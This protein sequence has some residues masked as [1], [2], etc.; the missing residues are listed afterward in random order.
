LARSKFAFGCLIL[1][2]CSRGLS[3]TEQ[4]EAEYNIAVQGDHSATTQCTEGRKVQQA[5]QHA[6]D[7]E[8]FQIWKTRTDQACLR[9][10]I[11]RRL[12]LPDT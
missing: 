2:G 1:F 5:Y 9:A 12:G 7:Q 3:P 6:L 10:G 11:N 4:A 8:R